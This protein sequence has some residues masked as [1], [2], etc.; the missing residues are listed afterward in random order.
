MSWTGSSSTNRPVTASFNSF[1]SEAT[2]LPRLCPS[3]D[4]S[5]MKLRRWRGRRKLRKKAAPEPR[6]PRLCV[7]TN[8][9]CAFL[10]FR[11]GTGV[12]GVCT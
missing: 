1:R 11:A 3:E 6:V 8:N 10:Q 2:Q 9:I 12:V 5:S 7:K 4:V